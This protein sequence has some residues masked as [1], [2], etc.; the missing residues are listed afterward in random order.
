[1]NKP[2]KRSKANEILWLAIA[3]MSLIVAVHSTVNQSF[4]S[5]WY[6]YGFV[7]IALF[8]Y[9]IRKNQRTNSN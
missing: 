3:V 7:L 8:M 1:M 5:A 9:L 2:T 6:Y 4:S